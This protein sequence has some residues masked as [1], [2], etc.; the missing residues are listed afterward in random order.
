MESGG[1]EEGVGGPRGKVTKVKSRNYFW[2]ETCLGF[3]LTKNEFSGFRSGPLY[4]FGS[5]FSLVEFFG[6]LTSHLLLPV[7]NMHVIVSNTTLPPAPSTKCLSMS[8]ML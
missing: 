7:T 5:S 6:G 4:F 3:Q 2:V 1:G 8:A